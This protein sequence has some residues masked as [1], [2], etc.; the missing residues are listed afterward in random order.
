[1]LRAVVELIR[2]FIEQLLDHPLKDGHTADRVVA[3]ATDDLVNVIA[4]VAGV[5]L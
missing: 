3:S 1:M 2:H 5:R 4:A